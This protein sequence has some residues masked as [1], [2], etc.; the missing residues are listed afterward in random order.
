[1]GERK[2]GWAKNREVMVERGKEMGRGGFGGKKKEVKLL[3][4][5]FFLFYFLLL[6]VF[7]LKFYF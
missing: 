1:M 3:T 2:N 4:F 6:I 5:L 7:S